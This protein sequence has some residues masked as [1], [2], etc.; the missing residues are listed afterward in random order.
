MVLL[1]SKRKGCVGQTILNTKSAT[2]SRIQVT[3]NRYVYPMS[4]CEECAGDKRL[5][6]KVHKNSEKWATGRL[7]CEQQSGQAA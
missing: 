3:E 1:R 5:S 4:E 2:L 6:E 7:Q